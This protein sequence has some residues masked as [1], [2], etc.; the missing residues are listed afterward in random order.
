MQARNGN[1]STA[2]E[3][4]GEADILHGCYMDGHSQFIS[5]FT[6]TLIRGIGAK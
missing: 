4:S 3:P 2:S 1:E 5:I 6:A